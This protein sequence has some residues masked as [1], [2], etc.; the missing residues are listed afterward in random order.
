MS[1]AESTSGLS[2]EQGRP[3]GTACD[4]R[5]IIDERPYGSAEEYEEELVEEDEE[6]E[7]EEDSVYKRRTKAR[8]KLRRLADVILHTVVLVA[9]IFFISS[10]L[11]S[12]NQLRWL[13]ALF[14]VFVIFVYSTILWLA[15]TGKPSSESTLVIFLSII[16]DGS[17]SLMANETRPSSLSLSL[18]P[19]SKIF[20][21]M[22]IVN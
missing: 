7:E 3:P 11:I 17:K 12:P 16:K 8:R 22:K 5:A 1:D 9:N 6:E 20:L 21:C 18:F 4:E 19:F 14:I 13:G 15:W 2:G 10:C